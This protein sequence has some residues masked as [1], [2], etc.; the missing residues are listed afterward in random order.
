MS[1]EHTH[2]HSH[3]FDRRRLFQVGGLAACINGKGSTGDTT[4]TTSTTLASKTDMTSMRTASSIEALLVQ[5]YQKILDANLVT[6]PAVLEQVKLFQLQH[7]AH[8]T[9]FEAATKRGSGPVFSDPN[10][11][12]VQQISQQLAGLGSEHDA[13]QLL[14]N[15]E[16]QASA[17]YQSNVGN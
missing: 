9:F 2:D 8:L 3:A 17:T 13:L 11:A 6:T 10:P 15:L 12:L 1:D 4:T 7:K 14:Y 5:A 16:K